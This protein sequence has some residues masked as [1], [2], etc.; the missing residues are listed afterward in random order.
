MSASSA[1]PANPFAVQPPRRLLVTGGTGFI[2]QALVRRLLDGGHAVTVLTR[3]P[4][5]SARLFGGRA[6]SVAAVGALAPDDVFDAVVNLAGA[7]VVGP[8]WSAG[9]RQQLLDSRV[10]T[11]RALAGWL[12]AVR[13]PPAVWIQASAIG[14]YGV[15]DPAEPLGEDSPP[16]G[17]FMA[18]LCLRWE[19]AAQEAQAL[20]P[21]MRLVILRLGVVFGPGGALTPL[22]LPHR[23][24]LGPRLGDGRQALS[25]IHRDDVLALMARALADEAMR[26]AYNAVAPE[27][28]S[29]AGFAAAAGR[30]LARPVWLRVPAAPI[31]WLLGEM[32]EL[33][34]GGQRVL[35]ARLLA[36]G[37]RFRFPTLDAALRDLA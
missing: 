28:V 31:R 7:P 25:W 30:A 10:G 6:A 22:L 8:R 27:A 26:G 32:A 9:R 16:G 36:D 33:F 23:F 15:R 14:Y 3:D 18:E 12:A 19:R 20:R 29:Q 21:G 13:Q 17:G 4:A 2:G 5:R 11:T 1:A 34:V 37:W 35:P 24:G